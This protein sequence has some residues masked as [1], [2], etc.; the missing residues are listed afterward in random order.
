[1]AGRVLFST[2]SGLPR[3]R[4]IEGTARKKSDDVPAPIFVYRRRR[5][6]PT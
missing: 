6:E 5:E 2:V 3:H 4:K 1:M